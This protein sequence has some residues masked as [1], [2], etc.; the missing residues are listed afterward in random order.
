MIEMPFQKKLFFGFNANR[1]SKI[2]KIIHISKKNLIES[3]IKNI[4]SLWQVY[5]SVI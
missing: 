1:V 2:I 4:N 5:W 3:I